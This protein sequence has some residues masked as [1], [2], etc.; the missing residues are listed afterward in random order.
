LVE[1]KGLEPF[2]SKDFPG[3]IAA[4]IFLGG[5][6]FRCPFCHNAQLVLEPQKAPTFPIDY[7]LGFLDARRDWLEGIC[8]TGGEPLLTHDLDVLLSVLKDRDLLVKLDTNGT[9]PDRLESLLQAGLVDF[10]AMDIKSALHRYPEV[11]RVEVDADAVERSV[12]MIRNSGIRYM[13]RTTVVPGLVAREDIA[14]IAGWLK[15]AELFQL[16]QFSPRNTL[17]PAF[18]KKLP[19]SREDLEDMAEILKSEFKEVRLEG[20]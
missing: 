9:F 4:T 3:H 14:A 10:V 5:C 20:I 6:N 8:V 7:F 11:V 13:F 18:E 19:Y 12:D 1:I 17:D 15:G 2:S 16:Q